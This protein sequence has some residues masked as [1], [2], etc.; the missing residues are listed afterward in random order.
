MRVG[1]QLVDQRML[2]R[3]HHEGRAP[4]GVGP[5]G[6]DDDIVAHLGLESHLRALAAVADPVGLR[7]ADA[8]RPVN[9]VEPLQLIGVIRDLEEPL[10]Q[11][12]QDH[13]RVAAFAM[14]VIAPHLLAGQGGVARRAEVHRRHLAIGQPVLVQLQEEPLRPGIVAR[15]A[16]DRLAI[17]GP[18]RA[19]AAQLAAHALD[20]CHGPRMRVRAALDRRVLGR[21]A[22]RVEPDREEDVVALHPLVARGRIRRRHRIPVPDMQLA[23]RIGQHRQEV[24]FGARGILLRR[25]QPDLVPCLL[26]L[27]FDVLGYILVSHRCLANRETSSVKRD[28]ASQSTSLPVYRLLVYWFPYSGTPPPSR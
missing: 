6:E 13:R 9:V 14:A 8:L 1:R 5:G 26:P 16:R 18:H 19:H 22:E 10:F 25:V 11:L 24:E 28:M 7:R 2:R 20:V 15:I 12:F 21:Q 3:Q 17:P 27:G 23:G 4:Q